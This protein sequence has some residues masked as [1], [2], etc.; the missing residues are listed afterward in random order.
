GAGGQR[1][2]EAQ[3]VQADVLGVFEEVAAAAQQDRLRQGAAGDGQ[4][5]VDVRRAS[6]LHAQV[7][8][9]AVVVQE[10]GGVFRVVAHP[11]QGGAELAAVARVAVAAA[12][13][14]QAF[15]LDA[16]AQGGEGR[17]QAHQ[18]PDGVGV[19]DV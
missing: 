11:A 3:A 7:G 9:A 18:G 17:L 2:G 16:H 19:E 4:G 8:R 10:V 15:R 6:V 5:P 14:Q 13:D 12:V 1:G